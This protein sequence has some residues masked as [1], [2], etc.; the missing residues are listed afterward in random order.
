MRK[1]QE[2]VIDVEG[3]KHFNWS[4]TFGAKINLVYPVARVSVNGAGYALPSLG[5]LEAEK[6]QSAKESV[7]TLSRNMGISADGHT[8]EISSP[9]E[10]L[11]KKARQ[12]KSDLLVLNRSKKG[13]DSFFKKILRSLPCD[14]LVIKD[15]NL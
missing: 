10:L 14:V 3:F 7:D 8:I 6:L 12:T 2:V 1:Y 9:D 4:N 5:K 13:F 15:E 11:L